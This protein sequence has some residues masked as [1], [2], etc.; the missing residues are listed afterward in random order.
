MTDATRFNPSAGWGAPD[1]SDGQLNRHA[2]NGIWL[3][4]RIDGELDDEFTADD[5]MDAFADLT[6]KPAGITYGY[7]V[8]VRAAFNN[9]IESELV[10]TDDD[11]TYR[12]SDQG[13]RV[14]QAK[15]RS[16][17]TWPEEREY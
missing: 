9:L 8:D 15:D 12:I 10:E 11:E 17:F 5:V 14:L 13:E 2:R 1:A 6:S 16:E 4:G 7:R 3:L